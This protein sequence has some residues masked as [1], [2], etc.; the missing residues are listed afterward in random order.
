[1]THFDPNAKFPFGSLTIAEK[2]K[3]RRTKVIEVTATLEVLSAPNNNRTVMKSYPD[4][5]I[6]TR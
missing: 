2:R 5:T 3:A 6:G 4:N 1:M